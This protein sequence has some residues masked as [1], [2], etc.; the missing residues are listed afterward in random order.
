[1][2]KLSAQ[3]GS[4]V[5]R[6]RQL[7]RQRLV[8]AAVELLAE[9]GVEG[10]RLRDVTERADVG[11]GSF[12][13]HF[14]SKEELVE[15]VVAEYVTALTKRIMQDAERLDDPAEI[16]ALAHRRYLR[17][18]Y[19]EPQLARLVVHLDRA[20]ALLDVASHP[21]LRPVLE[22]GMAIGRFR[23]VDFELTISFIIGATL[24]VMRG[25]LAGRFGDDA[26]L[27]SARAL[28]RT[29]GLDDDDAAAVAIRVTPTRAP[30]HVAT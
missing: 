2:D 19:D 29:C 9:R 6:R 22:R 1:M 8:V 7:A 11:F 30:D 21:H 3:A 17:L 12:Y 28:L 27:S 16:V 5:L 26:D 18:A 10:L 13:N 14:T 25:I 4:R 20:G 24:S 23:G 15:A